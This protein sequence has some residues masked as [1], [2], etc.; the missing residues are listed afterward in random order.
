[1]AKVTIN[2]SSP[3]SFVFRT[4]RKMM[5]LYKFKSLLGDSFL[6]SL[7]M[8]VNERLYLAKCGSMNDPEEGSWDHDVIPMD[9]KCLERMEKVRHLVDS[10]RFTSFTYSYDNEL[11]WA[12]YAGGFSGICFEYEID[13]SLDNLMSMNYDGKATLSYADLGQIADKLI[14]PQDVGVLLSKSRCWKYENEYRLFSNPDDQDE[15]LQ[16]KPTMVIF[17]VRGLKYDDVFRQITKKY[18]IPYA[19]LTKVEDRYEIIEMGD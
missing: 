18:D 3:R 1:M 15:Y 13:D 11:L 4:E 7:D 5:K 8:L 9:E 2:P 16:I 10:I 6:H 12:H 14:R 19:Y 17:G